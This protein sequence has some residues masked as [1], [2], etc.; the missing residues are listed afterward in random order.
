MSPS[1]LEKKRQYE[2]D[3]KLRQRKKMKQHPEKLKLLREIIVRKDVKKQRRKIH[4]L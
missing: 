2:K 3:T 4:Q 1:E